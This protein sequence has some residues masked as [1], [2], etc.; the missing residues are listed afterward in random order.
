MR[1]EVKQGQFVKLNADLEQLHGFVHNLPKIDANAAEALR[2][3]DLRHK[4]FFY[5][6]FARCH[7]M[8]ASRCVGME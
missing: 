7:K 6:W 8:E 2:R 5:L 3:G 4:A 1:A